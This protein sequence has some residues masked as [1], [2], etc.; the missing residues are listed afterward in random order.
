MVMALSCSDK[1]SGL[2]RGDSQNEGR[3]KEQDSM[4][5]KIRFYIDRS[6][7][8]ISNAESVPCETLEKTGKHKGP[9][10]RSNWM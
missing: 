1:R 5:E 3:T 2:S 4:D 10:G 7:I 8:F 6:G 9:G